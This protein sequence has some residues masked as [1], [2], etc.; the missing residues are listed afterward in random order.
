MESIPLIL[1]FND[2]RN[3]FTLLFFIVL[4]YFVTKLINHYVQIIDHHLST[5]DRFKLRKELFAHSEFYE[6]YESS[7]SSESFE[8][9]KSSS[10]S[11]SNSS[12]FSCSRF[13]DHSNDPIDRQ[14]INLKMN[15][16]LNF[17]TIDICAISITLL[18]LPFLPATNLI[19]YV[20]FVVAERCLY[21]PS[22][23]FC[24]LISVGIL[25]FRQQLVKLTSTIIIK[26]ETS[27]SS[28]NLIH[29][30]SSNFINNLEDED[31]NNN[32][33]IE[34][35]QFKGLQ[36]NHLFSEYLSKFKDHFKTKRKSRTANNQQL[37]LK[38]YINLVFNF[39]LI[40]LFICYAYRTYLRNFDWLNEETL[41]R[42]GIN[43]NPPKALGNLASI[44]SMNGFKEEAEATYRKA[45]KYRSNMADVHYN[46]YVFFLFFFKFR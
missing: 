31:L 4:I 20:G 34:D 42:S 46:L 41:Y 7:H 45:L 10:S 43:I 3:L 23:G 28:F 17:R 18:V 1:G 25:Q 30:H 32:S 21:I 39:F 44:L 37:N 15:N 40:V 35:D 2:L 14:K 6:N 19:S 8:S 11:K 9:Y 26:T 12:E 33:T 27:S 16:N 29:K 22:M 38:Q 5:L 36:T 24:L 13:S